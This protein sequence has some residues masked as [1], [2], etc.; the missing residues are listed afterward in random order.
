MLGRPLL[1][2][3]ISSTYALV[4][5][6]ALITGPCCANSEEN[7]V[8][9]IEASSPCAE[10]DNADT[11]IDHEFRNLEILRGNP[12]FVADFHARF[13]EQRR[14]SIAED[15]AAGQ[16]IAKR[17]QYF[18]Q[19]EATDHEACTQNLPLSQKVFKVLKKDRPEKVTFDSDLLYPFD[20]RGTCSAM[21]LDFLARYIIECA[22]LASDTARRDRLTSYRPY[23]RANLTTFSSRQAAYNTINVSRSATLSNPEGMKERKIQALANYHNLKIKAATK[24]FKMTAIRSQPD[25]FKAA[26]NDLPSGYYIIRALSLA[27][28]YKM[29]SYGHTMILIKTRG[30]SIYYDNRDGAA[31][32]THGTASYVKDKLL[33]WGIPEVRFYRVSANGSTPENLSKEHS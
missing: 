3:L 18:F 28:N 9:T 29:E 8:Q 19:R 2:S 6:S 21:A 32:I 15:A 5:F 23:Y 26:V 10:D 14:Q 16:P 33:T 1:Q 12:I 20:G 24:T 27:D 7:L 22:P 30:L 31:D 17:I 11:D 25:A 4:A 13:A